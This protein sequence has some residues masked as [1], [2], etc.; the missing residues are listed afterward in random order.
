MLVEINDETY[1]RIDKIREL[2]APWYLKHFEAVFTTEEFITECLIEDID[3]R[4]DFLEI[5]NTTL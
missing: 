1:R 3:E 5:D 4:C 2:M